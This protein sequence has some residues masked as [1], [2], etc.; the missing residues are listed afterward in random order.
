MF[1]TIII[2]IFT[3]ILFEQ[4][5]V[6]GST[7]S[8]VLKNLESDTTY[9]VTVVPVYAEMEGKPLSENGKTSEFITW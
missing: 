3:C 2:V 8:T 7:T 1:S 4:D 9:T 6:S 5:Q